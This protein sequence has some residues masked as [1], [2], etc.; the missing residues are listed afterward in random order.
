VPAAGSWAAYIAVFSRRS[1]GFLA[2]L[3]SS[4]MAGG[5]VRG[6]DVVW[7]TSPPLTQALSAWALGRLKGV[8]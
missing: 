6:V 8:P 4:L 5:G 1:L 7:G 3:T 2:F